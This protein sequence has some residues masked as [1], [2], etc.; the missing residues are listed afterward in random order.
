[1]GGDAPPPHHRGTSLYGVICGNETP[2]WSVRDALFATG[3]PPVLAQG[4]SSAGQRACSLGLGVLVVWAVVAVA[5]GPRRWVAQCPALY[6]H[7]PWAA[8]TQG[9]QGGPG[10]SG[11]ERLHSV[12]KRV[13]ST[14]CG[15]LRD[16]VLAAEA[17][18]G[19]GT[20]FLTGPQLCGLLRS[21]GAE[22]G[23]GG[24]W[25]F[26]GAGDDLPSCH[27]KEE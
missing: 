27:K 12:S 23:L 6:R 16:P 11:G 26:R 20:G 7:L 13:L 17:S 10:V 22:Q 25:R 21:L 9:V 4:R 3:Q 2:H 24:M 15:S 18:W 14:D 8:V 5:L 1:M 19:Q